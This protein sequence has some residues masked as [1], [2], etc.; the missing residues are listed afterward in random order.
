VEIAT[1][2]GGKTTLRRDDACTTSGWRYD[3]PASPTKITLCP[4]ACEAVKREIG[5]SI[6]ILLGCPT[7]VVQ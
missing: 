4:A 2:A 6:R 5:A 7:D 3:S 1:S